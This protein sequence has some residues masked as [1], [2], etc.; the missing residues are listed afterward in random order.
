MKTSKFLGLSILIMSAALQAKAQNAIEAT[1]IP[2]SSRTQQEMDDADFTEL[3]QIEAANQ[4]AAAAQAQQQ[5]LQQQQQQQAMQVRLR[6]ARAAKAA[7]QQQAARASVTDSADDSS[8]RINSSNSQYGAASN[9]QYLAMGDVAPRKESMIKW[10]P[11]I[12]MT[13]SKF[14]GSAD[15]YSFGSHTGYLAGISVLLGKGPWQIESGL[16]YAERGGVENYNLPYNTY[17]SWSMEYK[18]KYLEVPLMARYNYQTSASTSV[19]AKAG[20]V[21]SSLVGS[22]ASYSSGNPYTYSYY[23]SNNLSDTKSYFNSFETRWAVGLGGQYRINST[24]SAILQ[25]DYQQSIGNSST[26]QAN[27]LVGDVGINLT[28]ITYGFNAGIIFDI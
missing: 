22:E 28:T 19:F 25:G 10:M 15:N 17:N 3:T 12:G 14:N 11:I 7:Q 1:P 24:M 6:Q 27:G 21:L 20:V 16:Q 8:L 2:V 23:A 26:S 4:K 18:N 13:F 5:R 9:S